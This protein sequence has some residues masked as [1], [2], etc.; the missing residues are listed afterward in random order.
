MATSLYSPITVAAVKAPINFL[1]P[2]TERPVAY[3]F[4]PPPGVPK[5]TG[6]HDPHLVSIRNARPFAEE[7]SLDHEGF[8]LVHAPSGYVDFSNDAAIRRYY[9]LEVERVLQAATGAAKVI[10]F[11]HNI[12]N[13]ARA[14]RREP[15]IREPVSRAHNDFTARSGHERARLELEARGVAVDPLMFGHFAI[16][17]LWRPIGRPVERW[18]LALCDA[19]TI[20]HSDLVPSDLVYRDRIGETYSLTYHARQ[21]W[22]YFPRLEADEAILIKGYD[23]R[24]SGVARFTPHTAFHD[25]TARLHA[26]ERESI[27]TRALVIYPD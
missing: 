21:R 14:A 9:Y 27:E 6:E 7:L 10:A 20:Q 13:A 8:E 3:Q 1:R 25:T 19:T 17:N 15:G 12:R 26:P 22:Y 16:I 18:P 11:D 5:R 24:E 23:S 4:D 2:M